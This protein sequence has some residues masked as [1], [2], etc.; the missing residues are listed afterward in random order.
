M[1]DA[2][3]PSIEPAAYRFGEWLVEP[4]LNRLSKDGEA[5]QLEAKDVGRVAEL[6][7]E[8]EGSGMVPT[9]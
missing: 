7:K 1:T 8:Y 4:E 5:L 6:V 3:A 2:A 9:G